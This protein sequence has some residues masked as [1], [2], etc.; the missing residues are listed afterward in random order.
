MAQIAYIFSGYEVGSTSTDV[1]CDMPSGTSIKLYQ[2]EDLLGTGILGTNKRC[3]IT[4][5]PLHDTGY[6][7]EAYPIERLG[8]S[9]AVVGS[10]TILTG[11]VIPT[12]VNDNG[13]IYTYQAWQLLAETNP[14][15]YRA[16]AD[17]FK[18][19]LTINNNPDKD[20][21]LKLAQGKLVFS[22][23]VQI[24]NT[25]ATISIKSILNAYGGYTVQFDDGA[26]GTSLAKT[27]TVSGVYKVKVVD[28]DNADNFLEET[29][30]ITIP[31][32]PSVPPSTIG[33]LYYWP[34]YSQENPR[35]GIANAICASQVEFKLIGAVPSGWVDSEG[36]DNNR[37]YKIFDNV[38]SGLNLIE[39]RVKNNI[40]D[41]KSQEFTQ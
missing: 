8:Y 35:A 2:H 27:Y 4:H 26:I 10:D 22:S 3:V 9:Q 11:W 30:S 23:N 7:L 38:A 24:E 15:Q 39:C 16:I 21:L 5:A 29:F 12:E 1:Y 6:S 37:W 32:V 41:Y 17:L 40:A 31:N 33:Q 25:R 14:E 13:I 28:L 19:S 18:P 36:G 34:T 20:S